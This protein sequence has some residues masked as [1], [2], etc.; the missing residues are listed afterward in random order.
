MTHGTCMTESEAQNQRKRSDRTS[1]WRWFFI[2]G[3]TRAGWRRL[4]NRWAVLHLGVGLVLAW[5]VELD[6]RSAA[7][8]VLLPLMGVLVGL[9]FAWAGNA[10]SLLQ[11]SEIEE[12]SEFRPGG[13]AEFAFTYQAA[14]LAILG[15]IVLWG[16]AGL[17]VLDR[18]CFWECTPIAYLAAETVL[19]ALLSLTIRESWHVVHGAQMMLLTR[20]RMNRVKNSR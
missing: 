10:Q 2:A 19:Y 12:L 13:L 11:T 1:F 15:S 16:L 17:G 20:A 8:A 7:G 9:S 14:I 4:I 18:Q 6:L 5:M 3:E